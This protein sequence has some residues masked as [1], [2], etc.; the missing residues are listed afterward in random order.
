MFQT[1]L[2]FLNNVSSCLFAIIVLRSTVLSPSTELSADVAG[3]VAGL[4]SSGAKARKKRSQKNVY[5]NPTPTPSEP[6]EEATERE[7]AATAALLCQ[8]PEVTVLGTEPAAEAPVPPS[9][10]RRF[11]GFF[12]CCENTG[13]GQE[14]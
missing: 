14:K 8:E 6:M 3:I 2:F 11:P 12:C 7:V 1:F 10:K 13:E 9:N 4:I 5:R